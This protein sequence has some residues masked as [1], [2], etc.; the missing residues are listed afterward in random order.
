MFVDSLE[1]TQRS[2]DGIDKSDGVEHTTDGPRYWASKKYPLIERKVT[3][4]DSW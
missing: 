2:E 4:S 3:H 1:Q